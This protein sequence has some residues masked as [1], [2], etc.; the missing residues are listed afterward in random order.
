MKTNEQKNEVIHPSNGQIK[1]EKMGQD[2]INKNATGKKSVYIKD[3]PY[4]DVPRPGI[5]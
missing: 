2:K 3:M 1:H 5:I 4:I